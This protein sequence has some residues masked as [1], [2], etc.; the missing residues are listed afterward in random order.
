[1]DVASA[2]EARASQEPQENDGHTDEKIAIAAISNGGSHAG[3]DGENKFQKAISAWRSRT[4]RLMS[5]FM[6]SWLIYVL[7]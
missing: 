7:D 6:I 5:I 3:P 2:A 1:M 4:F